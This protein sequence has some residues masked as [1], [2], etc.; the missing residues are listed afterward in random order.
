MQGILAEIKKEQGFTKVEIKTTNSVLKK[1]EL[2]F[3]TTE[4]SEVKTAIAQELGLS[5]E[6]AIMLV[7]YRTKTL[8]I[9]SAGIIAE[10]WQALEKYR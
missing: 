6:E 8:A 10:A 7:S 1:L 5:R 9:S 2:T 3:P 4:L